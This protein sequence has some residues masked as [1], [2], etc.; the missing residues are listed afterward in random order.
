MEGNMKSLI[1]V[2][3]GLLGLAVSFVSAPAT[4]QEVTTDPGRVRIEV[5]DIRRFAAV[6]RTIATELPKD[7]SAMIERE[8]LASASA[9]FRAHAERYNVT[10]ASI[11]AALSAQPSRYASLDALADSILAQGPA[12]RA[13]FR[14][15]L[16]LHPDAVF[17]RF[18]SS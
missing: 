13:G 4:A 9:G 12:L 11:A 17:P 6:A 8:Y 14:R 16:D 15:L 5:G 7:V 10:G 2:R 3:I 1:R 18:G